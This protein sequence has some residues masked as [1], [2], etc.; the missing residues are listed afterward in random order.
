[1]LLIM[2]IFTENLDKYSMEFLT[3]A[4]HYERT[5]GRKVSKMEDA[6]VYCLWTSSKLETSNFNGIF[7]IFLYKRKS[8]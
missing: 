7:K 1:M 8:L 4:N 6:H 3:P 5:E 2:E